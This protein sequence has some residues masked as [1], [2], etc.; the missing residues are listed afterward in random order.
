MH[1]ISLRKIKRNAILFSNYQA[2][3]RVFGKKILSKNYPLL[4]IRI[5]TLIFLIFAL[6]GTAI[7]YEVFAGESDFVLAIDA[8]ASML[9]QDYQP[10]RLAA[11]KEA[12]TIFVD[13][14]PGGTKVGVMSFAGAPFVKQELTDDL[15]KVGRTIE[16]VDIELAGGT[17]MGEAIVSSANMLLAGERRGMIILLTDGQ[18]NVGIG[19]DEALDY[20]KK[21][22]VVIH[23][24]G[25]GT[26]EGDVIGNTSFV[27]VLDSGTLKRIA[28]QTGGKYY[29]AKTKGEL[30][31]AYEIIA[32][33]TIR[34]VSTDLSYYLMFIAL[35]LFLIELVLVN[36]KYRTIP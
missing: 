4:I 31:R 22:N 19:V 16:N 29:R 14:I 32:G 23:T 11:A 30:E 13:S 21:F 36:S 8:S 33:E 1:F 10:N 2:M 12:A 34:M 35:A 15:E 27:T 9:A 28:N 26:E 7:V 3:E 18:N 25:I 6:S 20:T 17:A 24:I 5:L